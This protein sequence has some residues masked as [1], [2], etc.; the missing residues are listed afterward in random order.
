MVARHLQASARMMRW[1]ERR[2]ARKSFHFPP[3][4]ATT[5]LL[6]LTNVEM[7]WSSR[8]TSWSS[9]VFVFHVDAKSCHM[10]SSI[11]AYN[12]AWPQSVSMPLCMGS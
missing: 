12:D 2:V 9:L 7:P 4:K 6:L 3:S 1:H 8:A 5:M 10:C 11:Y